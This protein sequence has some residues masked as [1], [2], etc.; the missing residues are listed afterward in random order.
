MLSKGSFNLA[1]KVGFIFKDIAGHSS[2]VI[3]LNLCVL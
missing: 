1:F 3:Y 2:N